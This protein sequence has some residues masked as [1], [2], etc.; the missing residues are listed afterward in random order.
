MRCKKIKYKLIDYY[1]NSLL[2]EERKLVEEHLDLCSGCQKE[3][4]KIKSTFE[5]L[6]KESF[7]EPEEHYWT[8]FV[9]GVRAKIERGRETTAVLIPKWKIAGGIITFFFILI[10]GVFL[11][12]EDWKVMLRST[13]ETYTYLSPTE[14]ESMVE[15]LYAEDEYESSLDY[16]FTD[17]EKRKLAMLE[18][19]LEEGYWNKGGKEKALE[20]LDLE[21][22]ENLKVNLEKTKFKKEIL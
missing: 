4:E 20:E 22:L 18:E 14:D 10:L 17:K 7:F 6:K 5:L 12:K 3:L 21:E 9:P 8:D 11:L 2:P 13:E 16:L 15:L 19:E 1:E